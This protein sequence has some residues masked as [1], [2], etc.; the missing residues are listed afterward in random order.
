MIDAT[1]RKILLEKKDERW[2]VPVL[3]IKPEFD[4]YAQIGM[5]TSQFTG[6][7]LG[8]IDHADLLATG[9]LRREGKLVAHDREV[10]SEFPTLVRQVYSVCKT[11]SVQMNSETVFTMDTDLPLSKLRNSFQSSGKKT[12]SKE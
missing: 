3:K 11:N 2:L 9:M 4:C 8:V 7:G 6:E 1:N 12:R 5:Y 10:R